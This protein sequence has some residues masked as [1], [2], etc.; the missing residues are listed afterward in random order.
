MFT[1]VSIHT[2]TKGVTCL[3]VRPTEM[4]KSFNPHTHE[5]C[6]C[7]FYDNISRLLGFN[8]HTHEGCDLLGSKDSN[9]VRVSIHTPTKGV[10]HSCI[11]CRVAAQVSIHT[12]TKGVTNIDYLNPSD[13]MFQSTHPRRVWLIFHTLIWLLGWFQS[14][15]P[16]RVW[17]ASTCLKT[18]HS[19]VSIHTPTKGVTTVIQYDIYAM[20]VSIHTPTKGVTIICVL[21]LRRCEFQS[22]HPRRVWQG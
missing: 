3:S 13:N 16:R 19:A 4:W 20:A 14:T 18:I 21:M 9:E 2:P 22:T 15:H 12:P 11:Q 5:G 7:C 6:D 8:P 1:F 10:T 17:L